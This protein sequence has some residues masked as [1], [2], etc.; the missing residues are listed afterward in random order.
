MAVSATC[1][2]TS[3]TRFRHEFPTRTATN[4]MP[5]HET[6]FLPFELTGLFPGV[7]QIGTRKPIFSSADCGAYPKELFCPQSSGTC[8]PQQCNDTCPYGTTAPVG[9]DILSALNTSN[10]ITSGVH[11]PS[12]MLS[13][14]QPVLTTPSNILPAFDASGF[15]ITAWVKQSPNTDGYV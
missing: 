2:Q 3:E 10:V 9:L 11:H 5:L 14:G 8:F 4:T 13:S 12:L 1:S 7:Q 15:S 6:H